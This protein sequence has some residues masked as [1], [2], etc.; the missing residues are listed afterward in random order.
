MQKAISKKP[1][2]VAICELTR[3]PSAYQ[4]QEVSTRGHYV[5]DCMERAVLVSSG[6]TLG[7]GIDASDDVAGHAFDEVCVF[8]PP[9]MPWRNTVSMT[10]TGTFEWKPSEQPAFILH[11][12][13]IS[14][15]T[16][17]R[18]KK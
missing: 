18:P 4:G 2:S 15:V 13:S 16:V 3:H 12:N 6:C 5:T 17:K 10:V 14:D 7:I 8:D 11:A 9:G 1:I